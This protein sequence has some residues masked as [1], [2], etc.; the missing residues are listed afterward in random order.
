MALNISTLKQN[1][2]R[3]SAW[4]LLSGKSIIN[5]AYGRNLGIKIL[6]NSSCFRDDPL[7]QSGA[8]TFREISIWN[9]FSTVFRMQLDLRSLIMDIKWDETLVLLVEYLGRYIMDLHGSPSLPPRPT[10][11][12]YWSSEWRIGR[13]GF[14]IQGQ[15]VS[16]QLCNGRLT[17]IW[18]RLMEWQLH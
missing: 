8:F 5:D 18:W 16:F 14:V 3:W 7:S 2:T 6:R 17:V 4:L 9:C 12:Q 15:M 1:L 11:C 13:L 10:Y